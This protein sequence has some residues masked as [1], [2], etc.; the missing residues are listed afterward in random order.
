MDGRVIYRVSRLTTDKHDRTLID[1]TP[2]VLNAW[3]KFSADYN[4]GDHLAIAHQTHGRRLYDTLKE[5]CGIIDEEKLHVRTLYPLQRSSSN[6]AKTARDRSFRRAGDRRWA[7]RIARGS[8][9]NQSGAPRLNCSSLK[10]LTFLVVGDRGTV[11]MDYRH[12]RFAAYLAFTF[13]FILILPSQSVQQIC[14][15]R[16]QTR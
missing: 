11:E 10:A 6:R 9:F 15:S 14:A 4:L 16:D 3:A 2:G 7:C 1:S 12:I 8:C 5:Y 13:L